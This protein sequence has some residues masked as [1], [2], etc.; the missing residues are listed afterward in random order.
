[1]NEHQDSVV[2]ISKALELYRQGIVCPAAFWDIVSDS[3]TPQHAA[4][5]LAGLSEEQ[6]ANLRA[7]RAERP[8]S[9]RSNKRDDPIRREIAY[10]VWSVI[11]ADRAWCQL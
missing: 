9:L 5:A 4:E 7:I 11:P 3:L 1:M 8:W 6:R 2:A 10:G